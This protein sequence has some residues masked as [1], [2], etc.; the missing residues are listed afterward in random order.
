MFKWNLVSN[1]LLPQISDTEF[2]IVKDALRIEPDL[3]HFKNTKKLS[4][5]CVFRFLAVWTEIME[6]LR[7]LIEDFHLS[8]M[9]FITAADKLTIAGKSNYPLS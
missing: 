1:C 4:S 7:K 3:E 5:T 6:I 9:K 8:K 2:V